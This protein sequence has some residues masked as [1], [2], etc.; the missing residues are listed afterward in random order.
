MGRKQKLVLLTK[1]LPEENIIIK[2]IRKIY[3]RI[4]SS[5]SENKITVDTTG[6]GLYDKSVI[7]NF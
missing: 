7:D 2:N 5:V 3:Y 1:K 6:S 4:L